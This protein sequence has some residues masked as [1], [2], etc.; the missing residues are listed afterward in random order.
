MVE[1]VSYWWIG[2]VTAVTTLGTGVFPAFPRLKR[3]WE[4]FKC[5]TVDTNSRIPG[6]PTLKM[7]SGEE[8]V[9]LGCF[10]VRNDASP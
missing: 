4:R 7:I 8:T 3:S 5:H 2:L 1:L 6:V 9:A 10:T